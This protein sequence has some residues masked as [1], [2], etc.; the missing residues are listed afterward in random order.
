MSRYR[1]LVLCI[2]AL[3]LGLLI[4][5]HWVHALGVLP[6]LLLL[7]CP[8]MHQFHSHNRHR[9]TTVNARVAGKEIMS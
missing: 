5:S 4:L 8:V 1:W 6:Y 7:A 2:G 9:G 3:G